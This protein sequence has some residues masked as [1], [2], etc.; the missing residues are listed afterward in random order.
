M[1]GEIDTIQPANS[2]SEL[3][4]KT[5]ELP[6]GGVVESRGLYNDSEPAAVETAEGMSADTAAKQRAAIEAELTEDKAAEILSQAQ[7]DTEKVVTNI[8]EESPTVEDVKT[9]P[10]ADTEISVDSQYTAGADST[11]EIETRPLDPALAEA[12]KEQIQEPQPVVEAEEPI[13]EK[14]IEPEAVEKTSETTEEIM[15]EETS[16]S[17]DDIEDPSARFEARKESAASVI[18]EMLK[19]LDAIDSEYQKEAEKIQAEFDRKVT[20]AATL[21]AESKEHRRIAEEKSVQAYTT[22]TQAENDRDK[23][24]AA[25]QG[26]RSEVSEKRARL[27]E[28]DVA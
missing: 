5:D 12:A 25:L 27:N 3:A 4:P 16:K 9:V 10:P 24:E 1:A 22:K 17:I 8:A 11:K 18:Q 13:A 20:E 6:A 23:A 19:D 15:A 14:S 26:K 28:L 2:A 7:G 21:E